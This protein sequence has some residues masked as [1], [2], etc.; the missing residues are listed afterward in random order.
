MCLLRKNEWQRLGIENDCSPCNALYPH[1]SEEINKIKII[2]RNDNHHHPREHKTKVLRST[3]DSLCS[4]C[5]NIRNIATNI[6]NIATN[7]GNIAT[8][9]GNSF[10]HSVFC[11]TTG[12]KP[13]PQR[14]LH[15]VRFRASSF[16]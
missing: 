1:L 14:C 2:S 16:K 7:I 12:P 8:S 11:L 5:G 10:I 4:K 15:I 9:I 6:G 3:N 13:P